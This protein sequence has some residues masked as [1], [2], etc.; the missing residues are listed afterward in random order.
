MKEEMTIDLK[1]AI[2]FW[3]RINSQTDHYA[4]FFANEW[5]TRVS[6]GQII[7]GIKQRTLYTRYF[8]ESG[9]YHDSTEG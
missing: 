9:N 8:Y 7:N 6:V 2:E 3:R 1:N 4:Q 5:Q